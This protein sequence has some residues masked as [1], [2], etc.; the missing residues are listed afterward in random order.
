M[1]VPSLGDSIT[2]GT[3]AK[4]LAAEGSA[5]HA[6]QVLCVLE[7]D[8]VSVEI[9]AK[10]AGRLIHIAVPV[11]GNVSVGGELAVIERLAPSPAAS[12]AAAAAA[13]APPA[14]APQA[15][16]AAAAAE[17][18]PAAL[19]ADPLYPR[20]R[21]PSILF[22]TV[23]N[24]LERL[25]LLVQHQQQQQQQAQREHHLPLEQQQQ[26]QQRQQQQQGAAAGAS[27]PSSAGGPRVTVVR[28]AAAKHTYN[29]YTHMHPCMHAF[30]CLGCQL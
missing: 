10:A 25:G 28:S 2:E 8:K 3:V 17:G 19:A 23:R 21:T 11:G 9:A 13:D 15:A 5:V 4:W 29:I 1:R 24:K 26:H 6:E 22:R 18:A 20:R 14:A 30:L 12:A 16:A 27:P 7:T